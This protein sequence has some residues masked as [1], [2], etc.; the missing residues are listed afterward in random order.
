MSLGVLAEILDPKEVIQEAYSPKHLTQRKNNQFMDLWDPNGWY[1]VMHGAFVFRNVT[2]N[3]HELILQIIRNLKDFVIFLALNK[4]A[5]HVHAIGQEIFMW[6]VACFVLAQR[7]GA[8]LPN[9]IGLGW[10]PFCL[11]LG[12]EQGIFTFGMGGTGWV[13]H[14]R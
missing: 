5:D 6:S 8:G 13:D 7:N 14:G 1:S 3:F 11:G 4:S 2:R 10:F 9:G 12:F